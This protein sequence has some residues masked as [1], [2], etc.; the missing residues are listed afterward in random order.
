[1]LQDKAKKIVMS[2]YEKAAKK[3]SNNKRDIIII[4]LDRIGDFIIWLSAMERIRQLYSKRK[5]TLFCLKCNVTLAE[6]IGF[7]DEIIAVGEADLTLKA[8]LRNLNFLKC[9][10]LL[11]PTYSRTTEA[12]RLAALIAANRKI[13]FEGDTSNCIP[14]E[15]AY[16]DRKYTNLVLSDQKVKMELVRNYDF[17]RYLYQDNSI[18]V[19]VT[20]LEEFAAK[21]KVE[22]GE[23]YFILNLG[24]SMEVRRWPVE[25]FQKVAEAIYARKQWLCVLCGG[26]DESKLAEQFEKNYCGKNRNLVGKTT[27]PQVIGLIGGAE[28]VVSN[29]T[30]TAHIAAACNI[31]A[32]C[33]VPG[34]NYPRFM[35]YIV[36]EVDSMRNL[37]EVFISERECFGCGYPD[38]VRKERCEEC[39]KC[40]ADTGRFLCIDSVKEANVI[41]VI[42]KYLE[43]AKNNKKE[44]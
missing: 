23:S 24:A 20:R 2:C 17:V 27:I 4:R 28:L 3:F 19:R 31:P 34:V 22:I 38:R 8:L 30:S 29:D 32:F 33:I 44:L 25:R 9:D 12:D 10:L 6:E 40:I 16:Y 11:H 41:K 36:D 14:A 39:K 18:P 15:K 43:S 37:P 35:P 1:M 42:E 26:L 13:A 5:I 7:F 21:H